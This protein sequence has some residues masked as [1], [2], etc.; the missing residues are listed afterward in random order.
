MR[1]EEIAHYE[2][3]LLFT[4]CFPKLSVVDALKLV[5]IW[6]KG[7]TPLLLFSLFHAIPLFATVFS[8]LICKTK[9]FF[10]NMVRL[11]S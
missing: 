6:S 11:Y 3:F 7:L 2:Q 5:S 10:C 8:Y 9:S 4:Q 1:K